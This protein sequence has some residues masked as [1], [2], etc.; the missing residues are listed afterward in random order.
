MTDYEFKSQFV[1]QGEVISI[2]FPF[3]LYAFVYFKEIER[4]KLPR[5]GLQGHVLHGKPLM[6]NIAKPIN[7]YKYLWTE[8]WMFSYQVILD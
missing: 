3:H 1:A 7:V 5:Q 4:T 2:N 8:S 6:I